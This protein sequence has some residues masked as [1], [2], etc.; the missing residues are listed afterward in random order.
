LTLAQ[1]EQSCV[2]YGM[3]REAV[4]RDA[5]DQVLPLDQIAPTLERAVDSRERVTSN[6]RKRDHIHSQRV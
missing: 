6:E 2:V 1:D 4:A 3:P 5:V